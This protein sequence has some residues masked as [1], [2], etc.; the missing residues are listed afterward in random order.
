M[1]MITT[2]HV[3]PAPYS[4]FSDDVLEKVTYSCKYVTLCRLVKLLFQ[5]TNYF[6]SCSV[7]F[8]VT[9]CILNGAI[10]LPETFHDTKRIWF[11]RSHGKQWP[12]EWRNVVLLSVINGTYVIHLFPPSNKMIM[13]GR[14]TWGARLVDV[15]LHVCR[16][17]SSST[18]KRFNMDT[19]SI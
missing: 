6:C 13:V 8:C 14:I 7:S 12:F 3:Y 1:Y 5:S 18:L 19:W 16:G 15:I 9:E 4:H 2:E 10:D 17:W 11:F